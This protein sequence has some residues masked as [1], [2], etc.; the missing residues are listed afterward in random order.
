MKLDL[1]HLKI[2]RE[3]VVEYS[4]ALS[5]PDTVYELLKGL[6]GD[7]DRE[8]GVVICVDA[9][10]RPTSIQRVSCGSLSSSIM[11]PRE[12]FKTACLSNA[13]SIIVAHNHPSGDTNP[14]QEDVDITARL[15]EAGQILGIRVQDH[16]ICSDTHFYSFRQD[17]NGRKIKWT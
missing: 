8:E 16:L 1:V 4:T 9:K 14:S 12:V 5:S 3:S 7:S 13:S 15:I 11:H 17:Y 10:N 6:I 2:V